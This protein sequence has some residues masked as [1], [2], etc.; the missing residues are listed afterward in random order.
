MREAN[1]ENHAAADEQADEARHYSLRDA[2]RNRNRFGG[3]VTLRETVERKSILIG[4]SPDFAVYWPLA[5]SRL[6]SDF[7]PKAT[8]LTVAGAVMALAPIWVNRTM[9]PLKPLG[10][11]FWG[12]D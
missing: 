4:R 11:C 7:V 3:H 5:S 1:G 9:F 2:C 8:P 12:T 10:I 6:P